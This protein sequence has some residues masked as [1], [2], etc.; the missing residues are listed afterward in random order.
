M[1]GDPKGQSHS[2]PVP[3]V[4]LATWFIPGAG[5]LLLGQKARGITIG[6]TVLSLFAL[7]LL[8][9]GLHVIDMPAGFSF[10]LIM[11]KPWFIGQALAG[12]PALV[13]GFCAEHYNFPVSHARH[14]HCRD[15]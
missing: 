8:I 2:P 7:G 4:A 9:G 15:A 11:R 3:L 5:Y 12:I 6:V 10:D 13:T 1:S 14:R